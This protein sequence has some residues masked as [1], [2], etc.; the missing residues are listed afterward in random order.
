MSRIRLGLYAMPPASHHSVATWKLAR[1]APGSLAWDRLALYRETARLAEQ[2]RFDF[3]FSADANGIYDAFGGSPE[4]AIRHALQVPC[5]DATTLMTALGAVTEHVGVIATQS[6]MGVQPYITARQFA[7]LD[8]LTGGRAGWN[9]VT[10]ATNQTAA[11][12]G[13]DGAIPH[14]TRYDMAD[15]YVEVCRALWASWDEYAVVRDVEG[16]VFADPAKVHAINH[17]GRY[18]RSK[19]PLNVHR[20]PQNGPFLVQ[21]GSS[22]R[23]RASAARFAEG[24]FSIQPTVAGMK[25]YRDDLR[26]RA[27]AAGR[28]P[29]SIRV[30]HSIQPF[31]G[32]TE[33][34]AREQLEQHNALVPPEAGLALLAGHMG[35]D[36]STYPPG[37]PVNAITDAPGT[38]SLA[39]TY[40][41]RDDVTIGELGAFYGRTVLSPQVAGTAVQVADWLEATFDEAGGDGFMLSPVTLPGAL[42]DFVELVVPELQRRGRVREQYAPGATLRALIAEEGVRPGVDAAV[43]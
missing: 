8:H 32:E 25:A 19:G 29:D 21:A 10:T 5:F 28:D 30:F 37:T 38:Q 27:E 11:N 33:A 18:Y 34:I 17:V 15:E 14:D 23:G 4:A 12:L 31:V 13:L 16:D 35:V 3:V 39:T 22:P 26:A 20:S 6:I 40:A 2:G 41:G 36:L 42:A 7:T 9:V 43:A 24:I 1:N